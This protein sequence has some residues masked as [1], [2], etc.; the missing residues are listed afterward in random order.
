MDNL[1]TWSMLGTLAGASAIAYLIV[2]Y[3]K[4]AADKFWPKILGTDIYAV[5]ISFIVLFAATAF[6]EPPLNISK[7]I[8]ALFNAFLVASVASKMNDKAIT[9]KK[10]EGE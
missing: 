5:F 1:Y 3:T 2:A 4:A 8:L 10:K 9:T 6:N 7:T